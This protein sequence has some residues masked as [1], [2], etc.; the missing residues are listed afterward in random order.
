MSQPATPSPF[1]REDFNTTITYDADDSTHFL[2]NCYPTDVY[3][4]GNTWPSVM[5][6][7]VA[8]KFDLKSNHVRNIL[9]L[10]VRDVHK[11]SRDSRNMYVSV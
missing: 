6:Y 10:P 5:H 3:L 1:E 7:F 8:K 4:D 11:Y 2:S 9:A